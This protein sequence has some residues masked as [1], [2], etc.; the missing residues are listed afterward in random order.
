MVNIDWSERRSFVRAK[1]V[2]SIEYHLIKS[3]RRKVDPAWHL[4]T[5]QDMSLGGLTFFTDVEFRPGDILEVKVVMS[6]VLDI[7]KGPCRVVRV[8]KKR[9][10]AYFLT[11]VQFLNTRLK[12]RSAKT[13][14][15]TQP[16]VH[17][18]RKI[19]GRSAKRLI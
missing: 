15:H 2:L 4:S 5:T 8:D 7:F 14:S 3:A 13:Y 10:G 19:R 1:R 17:P 16:Q 12:S 9:T 18:R 6:G 11:A